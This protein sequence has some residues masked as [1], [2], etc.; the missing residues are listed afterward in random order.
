MNKTTIAGLALA[1]AFCAA[2]VSETVR[3][4]IGSV[5]YGAALGAVTV[6][7]T[8]DRVFK[9]H[10]PLDDR[11]FLFR[12][13]TLNNSAAKSDLIIHAAYKA[14][15][16]DGYMV[17]AYAD[18][19]NS[20]FHEVLDDYNAKDERSDK[21]RTAF[22]KTVYP[23]TDA[24]FRFLIGHA[25][26]TQINENLSKKADPL[27]AIIATMGNDELM[28]HRTLEL[29]RTKSQQDFTG[30][31]NAIMAGTQQTL[32]I[33]TDVDFEAVSAAPVAQCAP[34]IKR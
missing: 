28:Q 32:E 24:D 34:K 11:V 1:A 8:I 30:D 14:C 25:T 9:E 29:A 33:S 13:E 15:T 17:M 22:E 16:S 7:N 6:G 19:T 12:V 23:P 5:V 21:I 2:A 10:N 26:A 4:T 3:D 20:T 31:F 27:V 18:E